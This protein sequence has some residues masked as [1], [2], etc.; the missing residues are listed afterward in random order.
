MPANATP[1]FL[2][3][4]V[5]VCVAAEGAVLLDLKSDRYHGLN[6]RQSDALALVVSGWPQLDANS[7][8]DR[9]AAIE[10][11][12]HLEQHGLLTT[13]AAAGR[14]ASD[15]GLPSPEQRLHEWSGDQWPRI[16]LKT[17]ALFVAALVR[18]IWSLRFRSFAHIVARIEERKA[19]SSSAADLA[20]IRQLTHEFMALRPL[21]YSVR[22]RCLFDS[23]VLTEFMAFHG[24]FPQWVIGVTL[25]PFAAHSWV[26]LDRYVL[27]V[28]P[29]NARAYTPIL[30]I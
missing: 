3:K 18:T 1:Y 17:P 5:R 13:V 7:C 9:T 4:Y 14:S 8:P 11:A 24:F 16:H 21:F 28:S 29:E 19:R 27:G 26:Q 2:S 20:T 6:R 23:L 25:A 22:D 12:H 10:L 30:V 15:P